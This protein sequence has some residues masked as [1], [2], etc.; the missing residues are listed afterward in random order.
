MIKVAVIGECMAELSG[1]VLGNMKQGYGGDTLNTALYL[2][3]L[4]DG[5]AVVSYVTAMGDDSLSSAIVEQWQAAGIDTQ[6]VLRDSQRNV[7]LYMIENDDQG[8]RTF[9]Y[10]RDS[11][12]ARFI[13][14]HLEFKRVTE[15]L[16]DYDVIYVSGISFAILPDNDRAQLLTMLDEAR[17]RGVKLVF[18]GN[19]RPR[20]WQSVAQ[21][22]ENY[23]QFYEQADLALLTFD[24]EADLWGDASI[25]A[26]AERLAMYTIPRLV[27]KD[28]ANGC[29]L[30]AAGN[31]N[32]VATTPVANVVDT[33]A[34]GDSFNAGFLAAWLLG[35]TDEQAA[36]WGNQLAG[37][38][39]QQAGAIVPTQPLIER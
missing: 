2:K 21:T 23:E 10:W 24:D 16:F 34:A 1:Q 37:Q 12:A 5:Q 18:D 32:H 39:I 22:K 38:V 6:Y 3:R 35:K 13:V 27:L 30:V 33:T 20:L 28:G 25:A 19:Y 7:G 11:A 14:Q 15:A 29:Y 9:H 36:D 26:A 8:E 4:L 31:M 17:F